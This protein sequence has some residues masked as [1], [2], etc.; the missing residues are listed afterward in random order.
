MFEL[1]M[2]ISPYEAAPT[3]TPQNSEQTEVVGASAGGQ[4]YSGHFS[5]LSM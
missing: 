5:R 1:Q 2:C 3:L 4:L